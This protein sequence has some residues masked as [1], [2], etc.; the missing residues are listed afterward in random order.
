MEGLRLPPTSRFIRIFGQIA[1]QLEKRRR[2]ADEKSHRRQEV[3]HAHGNAPC[4]RRANDRTW[5]E[6]ALRN[7]HGSGMIRLV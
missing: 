5:R 6:F 3:N 7:G 2:L 4:L 1:Q